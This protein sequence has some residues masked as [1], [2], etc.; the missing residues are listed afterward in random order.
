MA[1]AFRSIKG[2][3][4]PEDLGLFEEVAKILDDKQI[5]LAIDFL[6]YLLAAEVTLSSF[7]QRSGCGW[8]TASVGGRR[9]RFPPPGC[10]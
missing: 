7:V 3:I 10:Y 5:P 2:S 9:L 4:P 1:Y 6:E 8:M